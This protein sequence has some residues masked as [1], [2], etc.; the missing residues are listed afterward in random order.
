ME[1]TQIR[2]KFQRA[3]LVTFTLLG[4][5]M[6]MTAGCQKAKMTKVDPDAESRDRNRARF[7]DDRAHLRPPIGG[8]GIGSRPGAA[9]VTQL[10]PQARPNPPR[11][12]ERPPAR[13]VIGIPRIDI[14]PPSGGGGNA[15]PRPPGQGQIVCPGA[16]C[17]GGGAVQLPPPQASPPARPPVVWNPAPPV[18][19]P[20]PAPSRPNP[21]VYQP[22]ASNCPPSGC[23]QVSVIERP[24]YTAPAPAPVVVSNECADIS[25]M[26]GNNICARQ[27]LCDIQKNRQHFSQLTIQK[28]G[29]VFNLKSG[30]T[31]A[32]LI[33]ALSGSITSGGRDND[34]ADRV[35]VRCGDRANLVYRLSGSMDDCTGTY[36]YPRTKN[37]IG[38]VYEH[39]QC[40]K[41]QAVAAVPAVIAAPPLARALTPTP[42]PA[43]PAPRAQAP[44]APVAAP[45]PS[46]APVQ[47][48]PVA[49]VQPP[50]NERI[51]CLPVQQRQRPIQNLD[52]LFVA[53]AHPSLKSSYVNLVSNL[54]Q[55]V[56]NL[57]GVVSYRFATTLGH[58]E[59]IYRDQND[60]DQFGRLYQY[61]HLDP[62]GQK[63]WSPRVVRADG[64]MQFE[65]DSEQQRIYMTEQAN[66]SEESKATLNNMG[67]IESLAGLVNGDPNRNYGMLFNM[68]TGGVQPH[69]RDTSATQ[70]KALLANLRGLVSR[71]MRRLQTEGDSFVWGSKES[72]PVDFFRNDAALAIIFVSNE[73]DHCETAGRGK[74]ECYGVEAH[75]VKN[76]IENNR[77]R[78]SPG[79]PII[80]AAITANPNED[81]LYNR[82]VKMTG[83]QA[84]S[85]NSNY[86]QSLASI[87]QLANFRLSYENLIPIQRQDGTMVD[88]S[89]INTASLQ[90]EVIRNGQRYPVN[91]TAQDVKFEVVSQNGGQQFGYLVLPRRLFGSDIV[92]SDQVVVSFETI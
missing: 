43:A 14:R 61:G 47:A 24:V 39:G 18:H 20:A 57:S 63:Y 45:L 28:N 51:E 38:E 34:D 67:S 65:P 37:Y 84:Y 2:S 76:L 26:K 75:V 85:I 46:V 72:Q 71:D 81:N 74:D 8:G 42:T 64:I 7:L 40:D 87:S 86:G 53:R 31:A 30:A 23:G 69:P 44:Q 70:G 6:V 82:F 73:K 4:A 88:L 35:W 9:P 78:Y 55:F 50:Q 48:P 12:D 11:R 59:N 29:R 21:P 15:I 3:Q 16:N 17:G 33:Q 68:L 36:H 13:D 77:A 92:A 91:M 32:D 80:T 22:P 5:L 25:Q 52:V 49:V 89:R 56:R 41:G 60:Q 62:N 1:L 54:D 90:V 79:A 19:N 58:G 66:A 83:G 27:I 10:P